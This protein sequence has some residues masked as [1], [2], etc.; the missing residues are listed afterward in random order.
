MLDGS[1]MCCGTAAYLSSE[2]AKEQFSFKGGVVI[3]TYPCSHGTVA[4][5]P[6]SK[7]AA[8]AVQ[9]RHTARLHIL[10]DPW[11]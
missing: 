7:C 5:Q 3:E 9:T 8:D 10:T 2:A 1:G 6:H 4:A 11:P